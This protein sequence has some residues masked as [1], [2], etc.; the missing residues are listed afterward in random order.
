MLDEQRFGDEGA[1]PAWSQQPNQDP[2][3]V[4]EEAAGDTHALQPTNRANP[5][6]TRIHCAVVLLTRNSH[7]T[8][9][10]H[11]FACPGDRTLLDS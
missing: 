3:Q 1:C 7:P 5:R 11:V 9:H 10:C 8:G 4:N 6:T 2:D